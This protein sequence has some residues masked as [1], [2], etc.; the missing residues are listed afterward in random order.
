MEPPRI[1]SVDDRVMEPPHVESVFSMLG[2]D[3]DL[4]LDGE[5]RAR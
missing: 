4:D 3:L 5:R 2:L 1:I